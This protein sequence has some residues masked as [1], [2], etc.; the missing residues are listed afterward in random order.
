MITMSNEPAKYYCCVCGSRLPSK[1]TAYEL[2]Q[3]GCG[4]FMGDG[5]IIT[6]C[7]NGRHSDE[8]IRNAAKFAPGFHRASEEARK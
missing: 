4:V 8:D 6:F 5:G 2:V 3:K 1:L 7:G